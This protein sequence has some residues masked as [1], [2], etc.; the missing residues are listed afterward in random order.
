ML[1]VPEVRYTDTGKGAVAYQVFGEGPTDIVVTPGFVSHLDLQWTMPS[2]T[3]FFEMLSALG[4]VIIFDKRGTGLSDPADDAVRF[5]Q[6]AEDIGVVMDAAGS[7]RAVLMGLSEGGPLSILFAAQNPD[8]VQ[9]LILYGTFARG[10][11]IGG[12][13]IDAFNDAIEHWGS[14]RTASIFSSSGE[15]TVRTRL[16]AVFERASASPGMA[17]ALVESVRNADVTSALPLLDM[18][19]LVVNRKDDPFAPVTWAQ[20]LAHQLPNAQLVV[21]EGSDHLPWFGEPDDI[22]DAIAEFLGEEPVPRSHHRRLMTVMFTDIVESTVMAV[23]LG[24]TEW[25]R[26]LN[27]HNDMIRELVH[28][29]SGEEVKTIGDGFL[30]VFSSSAKAVECGLTAT[31]QISEMDMS[32]RTGAH[33]GEIEVLPDDVLGVSVNTAARITALAEAD[34]VLVSTQVRDTCAGAPLQFED[35]GEHELRGLPGRWR[36]YSAREDDDVVIDLRQPKDLHAG[37]HVSVF[38]ARRAP[39]TLRTLAGIVSRRL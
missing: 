37:D 25:N 2:Y 13:L 9:S 17:R 8:R 39:S 21:T 28:E 38:L 24:D 19:V 20:E 32:I 33:T 27:R 14:G 36:L 35:R 26:L 31:Q 1:D 18:P 22:I 34:E 5:D 4:R 7:E 15:S 30:T 11:L 16:A 12:A 3:Q 29:F 23:N 6:R 10:A